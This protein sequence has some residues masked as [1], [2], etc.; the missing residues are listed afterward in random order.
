M[1]SMRATTRLSSPEMFE[2]QRMIAAG[3]LPAEDRPDF[4]PDVGLLYTGT[5][6]DDEELDIEVTEVEPPFLRGQTRLTREL[7]PIKVVKNPDGSMQR[8]A[9]T[10]SALAKEPTHTK[11]S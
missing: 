5:T 6:A 10:Q 1:G 4:D 9:M 8:A 7:S 2:A 11:S 3:V